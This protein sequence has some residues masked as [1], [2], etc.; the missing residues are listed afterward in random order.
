[1]NWGDKMNYFVTGGAGFIGSNYVRMLL[2]DQLGQVNRV[3]VL[4]KLTY[5]GSLE[6]LNDVETDQRLTFFEGDICDETLVQSLIEKDDIIVNFAAESHVDRSIAGP[7]EFVRTNILGTQVLLTAAMQKEARMFLQVSTDEVYGSVDSGS[8]V[9]TDTLLPNSPYSASKASADLLVRAFNKTYELDT[10]ITRCCNNYGA[11]QYPEKFIPVA[12]NRVLE[13]KSI[14]I[15]GD[16]RNIREWIH[17]E[18]H[19]LGIQAVIDFGKSGEIYNIGT[20]KLFSNLQIAEIICKIFGKNYGESIEFVSDRRG[21]DFRYSLN[22]E[23]ISSIMGRSL[24]RNFE[25]ELARICEKLK[26]KK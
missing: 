23:K 5:A 13:E 2:T 12:I 4:D 20:Q 16:G 18:E 19:C 24:P 21:H 15:Y 26:D 22:S 3:K 10:R 14:P 7:S 11:N 9:E 17:V 6:N 8:S 1:M 25:F